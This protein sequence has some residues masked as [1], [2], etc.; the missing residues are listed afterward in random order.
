MNQ[1]ATITLLKKTFKTFRTNSLHLKQLWGYI[2]HINVILS[3]KIYLR[4][5]CVQN[6]R[7]KEPNFTWINMTGAGGLTSILFNLLHSKKYKAD[8]HSQPPCSVN[9]YKEGFQ[10]H[11]SPGY[12]KGRTDMHKNRIFCSTFNWK[13]KQ[14]IKT[15][16]TNHHT[17]LTRH[18]IHLS[19]VDR[20]IFIGIPKPCPVPCSWEKCTN[21]T[22]LTE[23][24]LWK[25]DLHVVSSPL[26]FSDEVANTEESTVWS[27]VF[28]VPSLSVQTLK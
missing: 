9:G 23:Q 7:H 1:R 3:Y 5:V 27:C 21:F 25:Q 18:L 14:N 15:E 16:V 20:N 13:T 10:E 4:K 26:I 24:H 6:D 17:P 2:K 28:N 22:L 11:I 12:W 8:R 19:M